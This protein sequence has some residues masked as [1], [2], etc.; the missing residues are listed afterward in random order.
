MR[1][2]TLL[3][4][5]AL[6]PLFA[7]AADEDKDAQKT[8]AP[9]GRFEIVQS[10]ILRSN[11]FRLDKYTGDVYQFIMKDTWYTW[12][13]I[14]R[15]GASKDT[16]PATQINYQLFLG[17]MQARDA[18]LMNVNTGETWLLVKDKSDKLLF[19]PLNP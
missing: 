18:F 7:M 14:T 13:K 17:G 4:M 12:E 2:L 8:S 10:Q 3:M 19:Q 11:T 15:Q 5:L 9:D 6:M 16:T 1:K